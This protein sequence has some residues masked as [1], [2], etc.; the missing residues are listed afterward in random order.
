MPPRK[1]KALSSPIDKSRRFNAGQQNNSARR[2]KQSNLKV[3]GNQ[4]EQ[5]KQNYVYSLVRKSLC[6]QKRNY[7]S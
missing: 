5:R 3:E 4:N 2:I 6:Q 1:T 7:S